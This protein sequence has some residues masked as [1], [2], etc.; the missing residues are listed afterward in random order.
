MNIRIEHI[1][2]NKRVVCTVRANH[3]T[4]GV[5]HLKGDERVAG[6]HTG[7][8][9]ITLCFALDIL[10]EFTKR[11]QCR[12]KALFHHEIST[13]NLHA[14]T[15]DA[16]FKVIVLVF[17]FIHGISNDR[18]DHRH[19]VEIFTCRKTTQHVFAGRNLLHTRMVIGIG[20]VA[21]HCIGTA[22]TKLCTDFIVYSFTRHMLK[23]HIDINTFTGIDEGSNPT[24]IYTLVVP[25]GRDVGEGIELTVN[26]DIIVMREINPFGSNQFG[27]L[28]GGLYPLHFRLRI[29]VDD[30][31]HMVM[32]A[33]RLALAAVQKLVEQLMDTGILIAVRVSECRDEDISALFHVRADI[34]CHRV[35]VRH[36]QLE[37]G[38]VIADGFLE[39][40]DHKEAAG[41][42][43]RQCRFT[44]KSDIGIEH[45]LALRVR[46]LLVILG[47]IGNR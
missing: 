1:D 4:V 8:Q 2:G 43:D 16:L 13:A 37:P 34:R 6:C 9:D 47:D 33:Y 11:E 45:L 3:D 12:F 28:Q 23:E 32:E 40:N 41:N 29:A 36:N 15:L 46:F 17:E 7:S 18:D 21:V 35:Q 14:L 38:P 25:S 5:L 19:V 31:L 39:L 42:A 24:S 26:D 44:K 27:S 30:R 20:V 10:V 22:H